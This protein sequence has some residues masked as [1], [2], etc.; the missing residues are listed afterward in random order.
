MHC[1]FLQVLRDGSVL[2][3]EERL[4]R[5]LPPGVGREVREQ[6]AAHGVALHVQAEPRSFAAS[7]VCSQEVPWSV[8][9]VC[10]L[11]TEW[12]P[13]ARRRLQRASKVG[14]FGCVRMPPTACSLHVG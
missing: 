7:V 1:V 2:D 9:A 12:R 13:C 5:V 10:R 8:A 3:Q 11:W 4:A 14:C 6:L